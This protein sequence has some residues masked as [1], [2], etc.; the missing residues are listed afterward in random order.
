MLLIGRYALAAAMVAMVMS[1]AATSAQSA[2]IIVFSTIS[3]KE[4]LIE[5][6]PEFE[7]A[8]RR[9]SISL[10]RAALAFR[11]RFS[12]ASWAIYLS[13]RRSFPAP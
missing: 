12:A 1:L 4:A 3:A 13:A 2:E 11:S 7:R 8:S 5:L 6:V 10:M 9:R